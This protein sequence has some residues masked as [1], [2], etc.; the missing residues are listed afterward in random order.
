VVEEPAVVQGTAGPGVPGDRVGN[1][2]VLP[3]QAPDGQYVLSVLLKRTYRFANDAR[4]VRAEHDRKIV[5]GD[6]HYQDP[7]NSSVRIESDFAP[8]K[9]AT[10][11]V[12]NGRAYAP[13]GK[14]AHELVATLVVGE[15]RKDIVI[16]GD[17]IARYRPEREPAF[18]EPEPFE[19]VE[20]R[21]ERAFGGVD[22]Y[23]DRKMPCIYGRNHLGRGYVIANARESV[24]GLPLPNIEDPND[25]LTAER[26]CIGHHVH[27]E[28][29]PMPQGFGWFAKHW[30]PRCLLAGVLPADRKYEDELRAA[31]RQLVPADQLE[32][33]DQTRLPD[34][35]FRF[36]NGASPGLALPFLSGNEIVR[37]QHLAP[38]G[39][40]AFQLPGDRPRIG[41]DLGSGVQEP[42]VVLHTVM[43]HMDEREVD[44]VWRGAVPYPGP[45]W[46][47]EMRRME[48]SIR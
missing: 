1:H 13:A 10:D 41:L 24:D 25:R 22:I 3:G 43:I 42:T 5:T 8:F 37:T 19:S 9:L 29:L 7:M 36:F 35:D 23:F 21:Y 44:L 45:D 16:V 28:R 47:P 46:L 15:H 40:L 2:V 20:I 26:L 6:Q 14:P 48:V 33:Y 31:Y 38:E 39:P 18:T 27:W 30:R 4:C 11:V 34:M 32:M 12:L 17:R